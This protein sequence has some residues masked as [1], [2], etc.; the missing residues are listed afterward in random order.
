[1]GAVTWIVDALI[2]VILSTVV[3]TVI[4]STLQPIIANATGIQA[5]VLP[6]IAPFVALGVALIIIFGALKAAGVN[7]GSNL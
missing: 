3:F 6:L 5:V 2:L 7:T 1:M 4:T